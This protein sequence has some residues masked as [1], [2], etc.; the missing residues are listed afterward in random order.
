MAATRSGHC[1]RRRRLL[2][3]V[4]VEVKVEEVVVVVVVVIAV[5]LLPITRLRGEM[6]ICPSRTVAAAHSTAHRNITHVRLR[7]RLG[8]DSSDSR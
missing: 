5:F 4:E 2:P 3:V 1:R 6:N 7:L 8:S